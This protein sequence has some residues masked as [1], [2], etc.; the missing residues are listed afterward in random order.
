[1]FRQRL[2]KTR[3]FSRIETL[4]EHLEEGQIANGNSLIISNKD[5][6]YSLSYGPEFGNLL[7]AR[8]Q[9]M[10]HKFNFDFSLEEFD[11][12]SGEDNILESM[13]YKKIKG[14]IKHFL[15]EAIGNVVS[16][17]FKFLCKSDL[18]ENEAKEFAS[19]NIMLNINSI[20]KQTV[21]AIKSHTYLKEMGS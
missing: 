17:G 1:M 9:V 14:K 20:F 4:E 16:A 21:N 19:K 10:E 7:D 11:Q 13:L 12:F 6:R 18:E 5:D 3:N 15:A 8:D 2:T